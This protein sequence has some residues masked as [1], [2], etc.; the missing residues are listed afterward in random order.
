MRSRRGLSLLEVVVALGILAVIG[1]LTFETIAGAFQT[2]DALESED[3][4]NQSARVALA[5]LR[6]DIE[7]AFLTT[8]TQAT[9]T[10]RTLL[11]AKSNDPDTLWMTALSHQ[12][13]YRDSRE[14]DQTE[15]TV[16]AEDDPNRRGL[17]VLLHREAPRIDAEPEK[18]GIIY[19]LAYN[20][21]TF[22][23]RWLDGTTNEWKDEWDTT[24][25]E[26]PNRLPRAAQIV[27]GLMTPDPDNEG[28]EIERTYAT[29]VLLR[30]AD[31]ITSDAMS[32]AA[33]AAADGS[34][35]TTSSTSSTTDEAKPAQPQGSPRHRDPRRHRRHH[36]A[37]RRRDRPELRC[38][39]ALPRRHPRAG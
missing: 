36:G 29:T 1:V 10:Y 34:S 19:P 8:N 18:E 30:F 21:K 4:I 27:L 2:R 25:A 20:V 22:N 15:V 32:A 11:V 37:H 5:R 39:R 14:C 38:A 33:A 17:K 24:G 6:R 28:K 7:L 16:W 23:L 13:L 35:D 26:T 12:R 3:E 9:L 31:A